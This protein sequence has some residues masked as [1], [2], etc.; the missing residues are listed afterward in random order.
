VS[1]SKR[2]QTWAIYRLAS[3]AI[4]LGQVTAL[5]EDKAVKAAI[6]QLPVTNPHHQQ[7]L[8]ARKVA[9]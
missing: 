4:Y 1:K 8:V 2:E 7:K 9:A 3:K 5:D 6:K